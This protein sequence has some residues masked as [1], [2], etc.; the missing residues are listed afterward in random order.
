MTEHTDQYII[1]YCGDHLI[2]FTIRN[3]PNALLSNVEKPFKNVRCLCIEGCDLGRA[4][5]RFPKLFPELRQ[6]SIPNSKSFRYGRSISTNFPHL[7]HLEIGLSTRNRTKY[8]GLT[9]KQLKKI[10]NE[11]EQLITL[12]IKMSKRQKMTFQQ[13]LEL[14]DQN[15]SL[16][17]LEIWDRWNFI[18]VVKTKAIQNEVEEF[19]NALPNLIE[20]DFLRYEFTCKDAVY[21]MK[22]LESL[23]SLSFSLQNRYEYR[24]FE[25]ELNKNGLQINHLYVGDDYCNIKLKR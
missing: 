18:H 4:F 24:D 17:K 23:Q 14:I 7:E 10:L 6:L 1:Q 22:R 19:T 3:A 21:L 9:Q 16:T 2:D 15:K 12:K 20:L 11:N 13:F 8:E 25:N 5:L